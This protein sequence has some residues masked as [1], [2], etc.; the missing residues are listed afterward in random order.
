[1]IILGIASKVKYDFRG[2]GPSPADFF[3]LGEAGEMAGVLTPNF[4]LTTLLYVIIIIVVSFIIIKK[5]NLP[6][7]SAKNK[8]KGII[9][10]LLFFFFIYSFSPEWIV[11]KGG[12]VTVKATVNETG[13]PLYFFSQ[14]NNPCKT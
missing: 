3:T 5:I 10:F 6:K 1:M 12:S 8:L 2:T 9:G 11:V 7:I 14:F 13:A 4:I